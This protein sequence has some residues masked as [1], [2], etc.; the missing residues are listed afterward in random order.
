MRR[1]KLR[2]TLRCSPRRS[3]ERPP[4]GTGLQD[5]FHL[6]SHCWTWLQAIQEPVRYVP[7]PTRGDKISPCVSE[8]WGCRCGD[9]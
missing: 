7:G 5:M 1:M 8:G 6:F 9:R 3:R 2:V 4:L